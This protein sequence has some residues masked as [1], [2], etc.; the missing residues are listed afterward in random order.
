MTINKATTKQINFTPSRKD[1]KNL[2]L[3]SLPFCA[4]LQKGRRFSLL[5]SFW[6]LQKK[7]V[8]IKKPLHIYFTRAKALEQ[9]KKAII[10]IA[11]LLF[12]I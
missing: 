3:L 9:K 11:F 2:R 10:P 12:L 5:L 6:R 1:K 8:R 4:V 7:V